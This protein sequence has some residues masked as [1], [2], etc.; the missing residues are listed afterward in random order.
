ML[1]LL[2]MTVSG[3][4][5]GICDEGLSLGRENSL[6]GLSQSAGKVWWWMS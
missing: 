1:A 6:L 4:W 3:V 2:W 5:V